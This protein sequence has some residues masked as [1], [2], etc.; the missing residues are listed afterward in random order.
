MS[1]QKSYTNIPLPC[2]LSFVPITP[3]I[4]W[5][6]TV[7][8]SPDPLVDGALLLVSHLVRCPENLWTLWT[9]CCNVFCQTLFLPCVPPMIT[10]PQ[11]SKKCS[12]SVFCWKWRLKLE[13]LALL[14]VI[15]VK[16][17]WEAS[18][19][20]NKKLS[21]GTCSVLIDDKQLNFTDYDQRHTYTSRRC[22]TLG[23]HLVR[24][25]T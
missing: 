3:F 9:K 8:S 16:T 17:S 7:V 22:T 15:S 25:A 11:L 14:C 19:I 2:P 18:M 13:I 10:S 21:A 6:E 24:M 12:L 1:V 4:T 23:S 5:G 20:V